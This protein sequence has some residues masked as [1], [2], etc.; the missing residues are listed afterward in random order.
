MDS[1]LDRQT[2]ND[3]MI[4]DDAIAVIAGIAASEVP[5]V[6]GMSSGMAGGIAEALGRVNLSKGVKVVTRE[7]ATTVDLYVIVRYGYRIPDLAFDIQEYVKQQ[8][9]E[10]AGI[11][12]ENIHIHVQGVDYSETESE[13]ALILFLESWW[14]FMPLSLRS[15]VVLL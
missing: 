12:V 4:T 13:Q 7:N 6:A 8:I 10:Q 15:S 3:T 14:R 5:G 1:T 2:M 11:V 9:E